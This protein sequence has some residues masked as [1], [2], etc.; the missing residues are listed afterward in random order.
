MYPVLAV[1]LFCEDIREEK[2]GLSTLIGVMPNNIETANFPIVFAKLGLY[3]RIS[4]SAD[5]E[6]GDLSVWLQ[7]AGEKRLLTKIDPDLVV[8]AKSEAKRG[9]PMA[10]LISKSLLPAF[11][12]TKPAV[13]TVTVQVGDQEIVAGGMN[14]RKVAASS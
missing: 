9:V 12:V 10:G 14:V 6:V 8:K 2:T 5:A 13:V 4:F 3:T 11:T 7:M 1:T